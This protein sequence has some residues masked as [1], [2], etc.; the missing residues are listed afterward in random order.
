MTTCRICSLN[1]PLNKKA[2]PPGRPY[3]ITAPRQILA[4]DLCTVDAAAQKGEKCSFLVVVDVFSLFVLAIPMSENPTSK[5]ILDALQQHYFN[6]FGKPLG[7][8]SDNASNISGSMI[9]NFC[10]ILRIKKM[11]ISAYNPQSNV[12]EMLNKVIL[13]GLKYTMQFFNLN[14]INWSTLLIYTSVG[15]VPKR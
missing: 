4:I 5:D 6:V 9:Q 1:K 8:L 7:L 13:N 2:V 15:I 14:I 12:S 3:R 10:N 11:Q